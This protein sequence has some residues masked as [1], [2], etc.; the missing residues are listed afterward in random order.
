MKFQV[1]DD[2]PF[3]G[4]DFLGCVHWEVPEESDEGEIVLPLTTKAGYFGK[5]PTGTMTIK[6]KPPVG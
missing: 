3:G 5:D 1:L 6:Y 4:E 2:D